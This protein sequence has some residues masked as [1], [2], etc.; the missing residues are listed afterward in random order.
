[1]LPSDAAGELLAN[2]QHAA[3][4]SRLPAGVPGLD[5]SIRDLRD[6]NFL[7]FRI[8]QNRLSVAFSRSRSLSRLILR[9][10]QV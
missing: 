1:M 9:H 2:P 3:G 6:R 10:H 8:S 4:D 5:V 7:Q